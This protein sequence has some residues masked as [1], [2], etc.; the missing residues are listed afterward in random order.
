MAPQPPRPTSS[1]AATRTGRHTQPDA[2]ATVASGTYHAPPPSPFDDS[3]LDVRVSSLRHHN[4][5]F[6]PTIKDQVYNLSLAVYAALCPIRQAKAPLRLARDLTSNK[7]SPF[8]P[9]IIDNIFTLCDAVRQAYNPPAA[10]P[11][12]LSGIPQPRAAPR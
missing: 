1:T 9:E 8:R 3:Y 7:R 10:R 5:E 12:F 4:L 11:W 2:W 6:Y